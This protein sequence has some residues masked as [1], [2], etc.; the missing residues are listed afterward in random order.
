LDCQ[1]F[2]HGRAWLETRTT[3]P[4]TFYVTFEPEIVA[5]PDSTVTATNRPELDV[6]SEIVTDFAVA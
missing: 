5:G 6:G 4:V 2:R 1:A 3:G